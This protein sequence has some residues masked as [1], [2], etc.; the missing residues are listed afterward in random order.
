MNKSIEH[1][2]DVASAPERMVVGLM[3]GTSLDGLDIALCRISGSG[4]STEV[5]LLRFTT[6]PYGLDDVERLKRVVSVEQ[7]SL[8]ELCLLHTR[9]GALHGEMVNDALREWGVDPQS[10]DAVASHGQTVYHAPRAFHGDG[11][12]GHTTLQMGDGD[13]IARTT[14]IL[15][16][17]DFRQAH[18]AAGG[19][20]APLAA[21][22]DSLLFR[23]DTTDCLLLNIGGISNFTWLAADGRTVSTDC[24]PGN[25]LIDRYMQQYLDRPFDEEG[26]MAGR[27]E[28]DE[29]LLRNLMDHEWFRLPPPRSGG[30]E[31]FSLEWV[32]QI[33]DANGEK[34]GD[35][36]MLAT[37]TRLTVESIAGA[38]RALPGDQLPDIYVS[39]GG[40]HNRAIMQGLTEKLQE[41]DIASFS[42]LGFDPDAKEAVCF[43]VLANE[44]LAG[45]G[46][47]IET[48]SG[49]KRR[50]NLGKISLP[51]ER[52]E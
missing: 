13:H 27:G 51:P 18:T 39:G 21:L 32:E 36:D 4:E 24:G 52:D 1:L 7:V 29:T 12:V 2:S 33:T 34:P 17:S 41:A 35:A 9:L 43:A 22:V 8:Q 25:T 16:L 50:V 11:D 46:F 3:S 19:E 48:D 44:R 23:S 47:E 49:T 26:R 31:Q 20:G 28:V 5:E 10:V 30:P 14:G 15:T 42:D 6:I 40:L 45:A 38:V 37:L